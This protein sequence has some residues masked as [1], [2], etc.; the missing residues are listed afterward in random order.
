MQRRAEKGEVPSQVSMDLLLVSGDQAKLMN[1]PSDEGGVFIIQVFDS[2]GEEHGR[3]DEG[4][5]WALNIP[6]AIDGTSVMDLKA[7]SAMHGK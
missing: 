3:S 7:V 5:K 2:L 4:F 6:G 1:I